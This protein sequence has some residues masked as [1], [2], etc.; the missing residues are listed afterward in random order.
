M[1][2]GFENYVPGS[3]STDTINFKNATQHTW[4]NLKLSIDKYIKPIKYFKIGVFAEGVYS[5]QDFLGIIN[6]LFY[7]LLH[8]IQFQKVKLYS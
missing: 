8:L 5:S 2:N 6:H 7:Q 1:V 3:T 4:F